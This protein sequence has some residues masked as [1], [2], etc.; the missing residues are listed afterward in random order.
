[1]DGE[2]PFG[3]PSHDSERTQITART[4]RAV[5]VAFAPRDTPRVAFDEVLDE[6]VT[7]AGQYCGGSLAVKG[8]LPA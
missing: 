3:N 1:M 7:A 8:V 6:I 5:V 2:G 4:V